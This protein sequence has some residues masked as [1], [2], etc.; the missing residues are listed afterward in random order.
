MP[1]PPFETM[2]TWRSMRAV[3]GEEEVVEVGEAMGVDGIASGACAM[4]CGGGGGAK[5]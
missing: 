1:R 2:W 3:G 4:V 5:A